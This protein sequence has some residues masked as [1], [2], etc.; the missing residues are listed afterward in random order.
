VISDM[1]MLDEIHEI[2]KWIEHGNW[3]CK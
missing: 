3:I 2:Q 1:N